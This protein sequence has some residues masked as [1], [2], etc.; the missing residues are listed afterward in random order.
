MFLVSDLSIRP[1]I[2]L[3]KQEV[4]TI[5]KEIGTYDISISGDDK[6]PFVPSKPA[7]HIDAERADEEWKKL[8]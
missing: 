8:G 2:G 7:T 4:I 3:N 6:C 5:A 1:L